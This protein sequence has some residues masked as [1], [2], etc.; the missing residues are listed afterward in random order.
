MPPNGRRAGPR[1]KVSRGRIA[2]RVPATWRAGRSTSSSVDSRWRQRRGLGGKPTDPSGALSMLVRMPAG[3]AAL[4]LIAA[5]LLVHAA[6]R[7]VL[8]VAGE[9]Y[10]QAGALAARRDARAERLRRLFSMRAWR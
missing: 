2:P 5:G 1:A 3:R 4:A 10:V 9:P 8:V 7:A 6:F